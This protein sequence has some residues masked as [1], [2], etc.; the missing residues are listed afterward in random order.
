LYELGRNK[1][2][3]QRLYDEI[4]QVLSDN[5]YSVTEEKLAK[6]P[7]LKAVMKEALR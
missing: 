4:K 6:M 1:E 5:D 2:I 7:Y 3:Q